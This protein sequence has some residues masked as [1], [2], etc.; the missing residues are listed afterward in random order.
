MM[1]RAELV[2]VVNAKRHGSYK[3]TFFLHSGTNI[4]A[5]GGVNAALNF[6]GHA[7]T[8]WVGESTSLVLD[9]L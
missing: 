8:A 9:N 5:V 3:A 4:V 7:A 2:R 6:P 1:Q